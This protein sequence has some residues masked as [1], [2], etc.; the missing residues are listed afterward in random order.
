MRVV[1]YEV[2]VR[3]KM[4]A[5]KHRASIGGYSSLRLEAVGTA[6]NLSMFILS[7][8][9]RV[10]MVLFWFILSQLRTI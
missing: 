1:L 3:L 5:G 7:S 8:E 6:S 10:I 2:K 4:P 9:M